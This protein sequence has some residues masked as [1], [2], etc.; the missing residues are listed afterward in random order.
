VQHAQALDL[1]VRS[2]LRIADGTHYSAPTR[3]RR[4]RACVRN[5]STSAP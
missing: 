5:G 2:G 1:E 3:A 4:F